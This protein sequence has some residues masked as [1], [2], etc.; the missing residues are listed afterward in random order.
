MQGFGLKTRNTMALQLLSCLLIGLMSV[1]AARSAAAQIDENELG[2]WYIYVWSKSQPDERVGFQGDIQHRN[3][4]RGGDLEQLLIRGAV[5]LQREDSRA[6]YAFG[7]AHIT[8]GAYGE[9]REKSREKRMYQEMTLPGRIGERIYL[10]HRLRFEQRWVD[11]QDFRMRFRYLFGIDFPL[12]QT[13]L[14]PGAVYLSMYNELFV[15]LNRSIGAGRRVDDFDRNRL[16]LAIGRSL[17]NNRRVQFGYMHQQTSS[18]G[19]GQLQL[20]F[21]QRF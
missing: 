7:L 18:I 13:T 20:S 12:N 15:N 3:W 14:D 8:S 16:Y 5:T 2:A 10:T 4:D 21:L 11:G 1:L 19:K 6:R 17:E 9:S